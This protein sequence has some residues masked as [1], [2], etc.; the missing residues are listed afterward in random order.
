MGNNNREPG[1]LTGRDYMRIVESTKD[2][3]QPRYTDGTNRALIGDLYQ[4]YLYQRGDRSFT[5]EKAERQGRFEALLAVV[6]E[7]L[8]AQS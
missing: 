1:P 4:T 3:A 8:E 2:Y 6:A 5:R 7:R